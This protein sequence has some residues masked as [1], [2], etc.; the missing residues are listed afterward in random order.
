MK[1]N[2]R[3]YF[4]KPKKWLEIWECHSDCGEH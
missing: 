1:N 3:N 2:Y 4:V